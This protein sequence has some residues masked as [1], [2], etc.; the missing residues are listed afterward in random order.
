MP[1]SMCTVTKRQD[2]LAAEERTGPQADGCKEIS[3]NAIND[4]LRTTVVGSAVSRRAALL[5]LGG[6]GLAALAV[7]LPSRVG[8]H[9]DHQMTTAQ[10]APTSDDDPESVV[11][12]YIAAANA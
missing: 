1:E 4:D 6:A 3:M 9:G 2:G 5:G 12:A 7:G 8:A 10:F 11:E